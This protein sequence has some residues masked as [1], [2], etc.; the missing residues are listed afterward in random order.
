[1][2]KNETQKE[3]ATSEPEVVTPKERSDEYIAMEE[4]FERYRVQNP[5]KYEVK[6][7]EFK[8]KLSALK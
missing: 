7:E 6:K 2:A 3:V 1:M 4:L 5:V 8:R